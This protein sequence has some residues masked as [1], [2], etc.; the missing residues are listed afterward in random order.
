MATETGD[1]GLEMQAACDGDGDDFV[2]VRSEDVG[3]L[4]YAIG[5]TAFG[6]ADEKFA[7]DTQ[8]VAAFEGAGERDTLQFAKFGNGLGERSSFGAARFGAQRKNNGELI[9]DDGGILDEHGI[10]EIGLGGKRDDASAEFCE[11][12]FVGVVLPAGD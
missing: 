12:G 6:E 10:G 3:Q 4:A 11:E 9:E 8:N 1:G 2:V 5:V 7:A